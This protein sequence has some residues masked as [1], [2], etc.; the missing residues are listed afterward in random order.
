MKADFYETLGVGK[1]AD[2]KELKSAFRKLAKQFHPDHN[3]GDKEAERKF[4]EANEAYEC[5]KDPTKR[6]AYDRHGHAS[7]EHRGAHS[8]DDIFNDIFGSVFNDAASGRRQ[9]ADSRRR[10]A[11]LR[12][13]LEITLEEAFAGKAARISFP[14]SGACGKCS[15]S[16]ARPGSDPS[17]CAMCGGLGTVRSTQGFFTLECT[18][19]QCHGQGIEIA[20]PCPDCGGAGHRAKERSISV[21]VPA[22]IEDGTRI[23]LAGEGGTGVHGGPSGDL[24]IFVAIKP[25]KRFRR[26]GADLH[27]EATVPMATA[28][29][30][31]SLDIHTLDGTKVQVKV[32]EGMQSGHVF[33]LKGHGMPVL[34][35]SVAG[36]LYV[37]AAVETPRKLTKRQRE[38]LREFRLLAER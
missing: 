5:L 3:P 17:A 22:G 32:P 4:K 10:G 23:R 25:D 18:C 21:E 34:R 29:L 26:E 31:G 28:A 20:D 13:D 33:R 19:P 12:F 37:K 16:G 30:G 24:Y 9:S 38:L 6:A 2:E 15:G 14:V 35:Q 36:D 1:S 7:F 11:D 8:F 27:C